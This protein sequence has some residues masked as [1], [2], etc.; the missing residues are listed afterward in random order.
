MD[1]DALNASMEQLMADSRLVELCELHRT[2]D[3][4]FDVFDL[5]ENQNSAML[6]WMLD[7]KEGHGQG[8][9]ILRD[10]LT[11]AS[12]IASSGDAGLDGRGATAR[13]F[14]AWPAS[15]VRTS[16]FAS[17]FTTTELRVSDGE[18]IDLCVVDTHNGFIL[19]IENKVGAKHTDEQLER[20]RD[21]VS[22]A[23]KA[24]PRL[25]GLEQV[26]LAL[27]Y[28][29]DGEAGATRPSMLYWLHLG[30]DWLETSARRAQTHV[31]R[32]NAS[33]RLVATYC[34]QL[35]DWE[36][37][38]T[39]RVQTLAAAI[40]QTYPDAVARLLTFAGGGNDNNWLL[41][42]EQNWTHRLFALQNK[43][44]MTTLGQMR[45]IASVATEVRNAIPVLPRTSVYSRRN[46][47]EVCP[48]GYEVTGPDLHWPVY[49]RVKYAG[50]DR[51]QFNLSLCLDRESATS[52]G[53]AERF[54]DALA[55]V[56]DRFASR[57]GAARRRALVGRSVG[58]AEM[59]RQLIELEARIF[60]ALNAA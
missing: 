17:A 9:E 12:T 11:R 27:D 24:N 52:P 8:D 34:Q 55:R 60:S 48:R 21:E 44:V 46:S 14:S 28:Y 35:T 31:E 15:R 45:G 47:F 42:K 36:S 4:V 51:R 30:Y 50:K 5:T 2:G 29:H 32:G 7:P 39:E 56:D 3:S 41:G 16:S 25:R 18:R 53:H 6:A 57:V 19:V 13:F 49:I 33:A 54:R 40:H 22:S 59:L 10:L 58:H 37:P 1:T 38:R 23:L 43:S 26:Y 20:Y